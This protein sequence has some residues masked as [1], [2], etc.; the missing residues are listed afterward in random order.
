[1][2]VYPDSHFDC[3]VCVLAIVALAFFIT[4]FRRNGSL[5]IK[6]DPGLCEN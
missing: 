1:M 2:E 4:T 5:Q 6:V 3:C